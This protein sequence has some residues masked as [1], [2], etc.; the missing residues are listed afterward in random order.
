MAFAY[1]H[2]RRLAEE[3]ERFIR[4]QEEKRLQSLQRKLERKAKHDEIRKKYGNSGISQF[5]LMY[6]PVAQLRTVN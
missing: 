6:F 5:F 4:D 2:S 1:L 3:E